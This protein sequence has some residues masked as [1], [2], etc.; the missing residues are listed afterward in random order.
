MIPEIAAYK[1]PTGPKV[2][3]KNPIDNQ[4]LLR[5]QLSH[6]P[7]GVTPFAGAGIPNSV[8]TGSCNVLELS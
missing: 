7:G 4:K 5:N 3:V 1:I 2:S 8:R 6:T